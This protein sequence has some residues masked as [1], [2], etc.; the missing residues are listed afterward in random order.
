MN[1]K[2]LDTLKRL[3]QNPR[4]PAVATKK[5][6]LKRMGRPEKPEGEGLTSVAKVGFTEKERKKSVTWAQKKGFPSESAALRW[7][8][9]QFFEADKQ[10][11]DDK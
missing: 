9:L 3:M 7:M 11:F 4:M 10:I 2:S 5:K 6:E 8:A 1:Q